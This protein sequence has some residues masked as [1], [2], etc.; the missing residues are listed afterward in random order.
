MEN[1]A[2]ESFEDSVLSYGL[3]RAG[4]RQYGIQKTNK[5][6]QM[7]RFF[8]GVSHRTCAASFEALR[9]S[10]K[11]AGK[12]SH[13][14]HFL[15]TMFWFKAYVTESVLAGVFQIT[16]NTVRTWIWEYTR[17]LQSLKSSKVRL[18]KTHD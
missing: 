1:L 18:T 5:E 12:D 11:D 6:S 13:L 7:E 17:S 9:E 16:E 4:F 3:D 2:L 15:V 10:R 8:Y 14:L